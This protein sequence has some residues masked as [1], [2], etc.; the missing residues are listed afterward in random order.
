MKKAARKARASLGGLARANALSAARR[1]AI[2]K[3]ASAERWRRA[4]PARVKKLLA[5][6]ARLSKQF[7]R[8]KSES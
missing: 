7:E 1:K 8:K 4:V 3:K 5:K 6:A 2:A